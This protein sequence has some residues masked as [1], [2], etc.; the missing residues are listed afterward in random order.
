M[1]IKNFS[2]I[3]SE[4]QK[5]RS[6]VVLRRKGGVCLIYVFIKEIRQLK[7]V[8]LGFLPPKYIYELLVFYLGVQC[9]CSRQL[10]FASSMLSILL[11]T[12]ATYL[13]NVVT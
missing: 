8:N 11:V 10:T 12:P 5:N 13:L 4:I 2:K 7:A 6:V 3:L 1:R 9:L